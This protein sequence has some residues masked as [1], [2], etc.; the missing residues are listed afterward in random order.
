M[1]IEKN[2]LS[3][4]GKTV[5]VMVDRPA[6]SVHPDHP[7]LVY[8][9]NYGYV[10]GIIALDGEEQDAYILGVSEPLKSFT[11]VVIAIICR[12]DDAEDKWVCVPEE[13]AGSELCYECNILHQVNFQEQYFKSKLFPLYEKTS[14]A[15]LYTEKDGERRYLLIK[16]DSGH[17]G[18][19]K[20]HIEYG[21]TEYENA[22][23]EI[24][25]ETGLP[26]EPHPG[27]REEYTFT[28]LENTR[29]TSVFFLSHYDYRPPVFQEEEV[30]D[31]WLLPYEA[32]MDK[33]NW[34]QDREVL[35]SA[36]E[37]LRKLSD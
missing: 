27:F 11:G 14:G 25:E 5:T 13:I 2:D 29:K 32:A 24:R 4:L 28:T 36:E 3:F 19:P 23:R 26:F 35:R 17:I 9:I 12:E 18:F 31:D 30:M 1:R 33:L 10:E 15:V 16:S 34:Q 21:E 37:F 8:P 6:G 7:E 20:G 22:A